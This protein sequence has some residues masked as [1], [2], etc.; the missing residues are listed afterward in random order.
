MFRISHPGSKHSNAL[1][2]STYRQVATLGFVPIESPFLCIEAGATPEDLDRFIGVEHADQTLPVGDLYSEAAKGKKADNYRS[3][4]GVASVR[5]ISRSGLL[6]EVGGIDLTHFKRNP[7]ALA[8]HYQIVPATLEPAVI[9]MVGKVQAIDGKTLAFKNMTFDTDPLSEAWLQ[10]IRGGF[11]RMLSIGVLPVKVEYVEEEKGKGE[12]KRMVRYLRF[13]ES[14][15]VE[16]SPCGI[17]ANRGAFIDPGERKPQ[18]SEELLGLVSKLMVELEELR[19]VVYDTADD[20]SEE[21]YG[22]ASFPDAA[23]I[24]EKDAPKENGKTVHK[25]RHLPHHTKSAK[26]PTEN[27]TVDLPHLRNALARVGQVNPHKESKESYVRRAR[28]HLNAHAKVLLKSRRDEVAALEQLVDDEIDE[29][30]W[31]TLADTAAKFRGNP[32]SP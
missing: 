27:G 7:V 2:E 20:G 21:A 26:S 9:A 14:E 4:S 15:L 6:I 24:V 5:G 13:V 10:K 1:I 3:V 22:D 17:G 29:S 8:C 32:Q 25:Y 12:N 28:A 23:F 19:G 18:S 31:K 16:I 30:L 11:V